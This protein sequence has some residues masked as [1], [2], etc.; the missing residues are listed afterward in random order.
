MVRGE[1]PVGT[2]WRS[3]DD[4]DEDDEKGWLM[5]EGANDP[6]E[7]LGIFDL[8]HP[9]LLAIFSVPDPDT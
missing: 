6:E 8:I 4:E 1:T 7:G 5:S 9:L 3:D 2:E